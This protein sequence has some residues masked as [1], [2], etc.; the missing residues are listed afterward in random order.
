MNQPVKASFAERFFKLKDHHTT[1]KT[2][3]IAGVTT[4][5][6][7]AYIFAV[8]PG[9]LADAGMDKGAVFTAT[10]L[11]SI[12]ATLLMGLYANLPFAL[13]A[14]M[15]LNAF[16]AYTVVLA[17]GHTW[18][19][20]LTAVFLEGIIFILL[21]LFKVREMIVDGMPTVIKNAVS[22]GIGIF[23]AFIGL[24]SAGIIVGDEGN[25][26]KLGNLTTGHALVCLVGIVLILGLSI[27][28]VKGAILIG[29]VA[30]TLVG[31]PA[32]VTHLD[33]LV[34]MPPSIAPTAM[35][36]TNFSMKEI[37][38]M[39]ML[40]VVFTFLFIDMFDTIGTLIGTATK[41]NM[42]DENGK[43]PKAGRAL[44]SDA[45]GTTVGAMLGTSTV[46][47]FVESSAGIAEGGRT[48]LTAV[49]T[50][51]LMVLALFFSP[52]FLVIPGS[53]T[54]AA[55][56]VVGL[57]MISS[58]NK[59]DFNDYSDG[60]PAFVTIIIMPLAGSIGDGLMLGIIFYVIAKLVARKFNEISVFMYV[61]A[62]IF[63]LKYTA[64]LWQHLFA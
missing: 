2:E 45:I 35:A 16:F 3:I 15:G 9:I 5:V 22:A 50:A 54:A 58:V 6:T 61:L 12:I 19:F 33:G 10:A 13:S 60:F 21:S 62:I 51:I 18:Q 23:I 40:V 38:S 8:N 20:A 14:G 28:K 47:T 37:F 41:A 52:F 11:A 27:M 29:I 39:D 53:A 17:M 44:L 34:A 36:F 63:V 64:P 32:G 59:I 55:L 57:F 43:L 31:I 7:M 26:V 1:V 4:F 24:K 25:V 49:T 48:G 30:A 42:L 46:T 56:I